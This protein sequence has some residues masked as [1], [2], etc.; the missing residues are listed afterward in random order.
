[1]LIRSF[2][3][4]VVLGAVGGFAFSW[5]LLSK[6]T[7]RSVAGVFDVPIN[8][9]DKAQRMAR[10]RTIGYIKGLR[11]GACNFTAMLGAVVGLAVWII[12]QV[13]AW[14]FG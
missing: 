11:L 1:M 8:P 14:V 4:C 9:N 5:R 13:A 6:S 3:L 12:W 10:A 7:A 2:F